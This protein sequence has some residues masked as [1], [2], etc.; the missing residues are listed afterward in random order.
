MR[1]LLLSL[2]YFVTIKTFS[3]EVVQQERVQKFKWKNLEVVYLKDNQYPTYN[4]SIYFADGAL[5]DNRRRTGETSQMFSLLTSGTRRFSQKDILE[6]LEFFGT[7]YGSNVT[8][9][10]SVFSVSGLT[11]DIVPTMKKVCHLFQDTTFSRRIL[12]REKHLSISKLK[13]IVN[14]RGSLATRAFREI[15]LKGT[16]YEKPVNG[17][18]KGIRKI[19]RRDLVRKLDYFNNKV[20]KRIYLSGSKDVLHLKKIFL[21][22]CGWG[23]EK[24]KFVRS[25]KFNKTLRKKPQVTLVVIPQANQAQIRIGRY[26]NPGESNDIEKLK[27]SSEILGGRGLTSLMMSELRVKRGLIYS[28]GG[29]ASKQKDYGRVVLSTYTRNEKV[30][31][32]LDVLEDLLFKA[33]T[34]RLDKIHFERSKKAVIGAYPFKFE[35]TDDF[36]GRLLFYDHI[37]KSYSEFFNSREKIK[38]LSYDSIKPDLKRVFDWDKMEIV[39]LGSGKILKKI[40]KKKFKKVRVI[41]Y[42]NYL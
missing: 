4:V 38:R 28:G 16:P 6:N 13:S 31:E 42:K 22:D 27:L 12:S 36:L 15:S 33:K 2:V 32:V 17:K 10:Y 20:L 25:K 26:I 29:N 3:K 21:N 34:G 35:R 41:S 1:Y 40:L 39:I 24:A 14:N 19:K 30:I 37:G 8:H 7:K 5:S 18:L 23:S 9:E 11:K